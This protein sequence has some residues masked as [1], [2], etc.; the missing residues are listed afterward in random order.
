[1]SA[2][3]SFQTRQLDEQA[4]SEFVSSR[5]PVLDMADKQ[6]FLAQGAALHLIQ[7]DE[8][9]GAK[10]GARNPTADESSIIARAYRPN[11][12]TSRV[13]N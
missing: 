12:E 9:C 4:N 8:K 6:T 3:G 13:A 5:A 11:M 2:S 7:S 10:C 1:M